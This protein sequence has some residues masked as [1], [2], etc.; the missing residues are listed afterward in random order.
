MLV[1]DSS[2]SD[3]SCGLAHQ[4]CAKSEN[5]T[6]WLC[7]VVQRSVVSY[8]FN[9]FDVE[10]NSLELTYFLDWFDKISGYLCV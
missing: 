10:G 7:N 5:V 2:S 8:V 9:A 3:L 6:T 4:D 1:N